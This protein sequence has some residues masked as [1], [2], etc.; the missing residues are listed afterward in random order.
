MTLI[1]EPRTL[2]QAALKAAELYE[3]ERG[4]REA[5]RAAELDPA[6]REEAR[7]SFE[8]ADAARHAR[9]TVLRQWRLL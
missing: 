4:L 2:H 3:I 8:R 1:G 5:G 6:R 7:Q 9:L